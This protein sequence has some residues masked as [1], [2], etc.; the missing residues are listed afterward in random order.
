[1][2]MAEVQAVVDEVLEAGFTALKVDLDIRAYGHTGSETGW[3]ENSEIVPDIL[4]YNT[5]D[6][7]AAGHDA[8]L[9]AAV[10][11]LLNNL[12]PNGAKKK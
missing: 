7:V 9:E 2:N 10:T 1:M 4:V 5:P 8:Q 6:D 12:P 3:Y 11:H